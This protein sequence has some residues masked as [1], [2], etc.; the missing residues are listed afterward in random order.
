LVLQGKVFEPFV[1]MNL[2]PKS[3]CQVKRRQVNS[4][5]FTKLVTPKLYNIAT[6]SK[7][8]K[9]TA[10]PLAKS[11]L[12]QGRSSETQ[13]LGNESAARKVGDL[14]SLLAIQSQ[15]LPGLLLSSKGH[16]A[17]RTK[18]QD[19]CQRHSD[20]KKLERLS[21]SFNP[22]GQLLQRDRSFASSGLSRS[23][24]ANHL[25]SSGW[26]VEVVSGAKSSLDSKILT[27]SSSKLSSIA[28]EVEVGSS[29]GE[30]TKTFVNPLVK[31]R[32]SHQ[33][34]FSDGCS[35]QSASRHRPVAMFRSRSQQNV[36][37]NFTKWK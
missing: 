29:S 13:P 2:S 9:S 24:V 7:A 32:K 15:R 28:F 4:R 5:V 11:L 6:H 31:E 16:L 8:A 34:V 17:W 30:P 12:S 33:Q 22:D 19:T 25:S 18:V 26:E 36:F 21:S 27:C 3:R 1:N 14:R 37:E 35:N 10:G 20:V 23:M